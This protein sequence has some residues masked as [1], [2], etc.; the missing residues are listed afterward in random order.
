MIGFSELLKKKERTVIGILS[1]TSVDAVD[2]VLVK[3]RGSGS[4]SKVNVLDFKSFPIS[5][6]LKEKILDVSGKHTGQVDELCRLNVILGNLYGK[7]VNKFISLNNI[8]RDKIDLIGSHG[9][10]VHHLPVKEERFGIKSCSTL[11]IGDP[12]VIAN[13]TGITTVGD[14]RMADIAAGGSGAPLVPYLD[15]ILFGSPNADRLLVNIGG[16]SNVTYLPKKLE[17]SKLIAFD[18]GPGNMIIDY[19]MMKLTG[20]KF[21]KNGTMAFKGKVNQQLFDFISRTDSYYSAKPPKSTGREYYG[22]D[23]SEKILRFGKRISTEDIISTVTVFTA[24]AIFENVK[25]L[26]IDELIVSGGGSKNKAIIQAL[27]SFFMRSKVKCLDEKGINSENK[28]AVL[29]ALLA[30]EIISGNKANITSVTGANKNV[31]LGK[32]CPA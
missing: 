30:N 5:I 22:R 21:D 11:Q 1:G 8:S 6:E 3:I 14:F 12:S 16:I 2:A 20:K 13:V 31:Y 27:S 26:K 23:F 25:N 32:I 9:Q 18:T 19:V 4:K 17:S 7:C 28:E 10:T 15:Q 29:F 24:F